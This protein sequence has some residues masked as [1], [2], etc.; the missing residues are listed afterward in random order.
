MPDYQNGLIYK[1]C[2]KD[3]DI[4][5]IYIGSTTSFRHRKAHHKSNCNN[6]KSCSY[7]L[8]VY[9][10]IRENGGWENW[11]MVLLEYYKCD[12]KLELEKREREV[13]ENLKSS[14]NQVIPRRSIK[15]YYQDNKEQILEKQKEYYQD[16]KNHIKQYIKKYY[17]D[18]KEHYK[19]YRQDNKEQIKE[20]S[21]KYREDNKE[22]Y[23][24][25]K[26]EYYEKNKD[27]ILEKRKEK[28][29]CECGAIITKPMFNRHTKS[30]KHQGYFIL[31]NNV[32]NI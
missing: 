14:L 24:E 32:N 13:I 12:S 31:K 8:D 2:C 5:D 20:Q 7:N 22:Y 10:F 28:I 30:I 26:K 3:T 21:K 18:N 29:T 11:N 6:E 4:T 15:E 16:N 1:L 23:K 19:E 27:K 9:K 25:K 17:Q